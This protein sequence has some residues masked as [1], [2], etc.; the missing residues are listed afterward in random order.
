[1]LS[2]KNLSDNSK[3]LQ[4]FISSMPYEDINLLRQR[5]L[6]FGKENVA[7][8]S[9]DDSSRSTCLASNIYRSDIDGSEENHELI[10]N[11]NRLNFNHPI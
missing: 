9:N 1:M 6:N 10:T 7:N 4:E 3:L 5:L 2:E 8:H 11:N